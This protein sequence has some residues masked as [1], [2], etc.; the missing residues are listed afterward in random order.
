MEN[1]VTHSQKPERRIQK[2]ESEIHNN[3]NNSSSSHCFIA[4]WHQN[5]LV[6]EETFNLSKLAAAVKS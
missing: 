3:N 6:S 4:R 5:V 1:P 2:R